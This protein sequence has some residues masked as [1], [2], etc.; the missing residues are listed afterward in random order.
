MC[1]NVADV[2]KSLEFAQ[3]WRLLSSFFCNTSFKSHDAHNNLTFLQLTSP[4]ASTKIVD[5]D[6][7]KYHAEDDNLSLA[8]SYPASEQLPVFLCTYLCRVTYSYTTWNIKQE[9][10]F[11]YN[12]IF[13]SYNCVPT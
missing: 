8:S 9:L 7:Q 1:N 10:S 13:W 11:W 4:L 6:N 5:T 12:V 2:V 3:L